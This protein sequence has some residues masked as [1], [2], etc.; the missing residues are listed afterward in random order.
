MSCLFNTKCSAPKVKYQ[1]RLYQTEADV[2]GNTVYRGQIVAIVVTL[3][4][5]VDVAAPIAAPDISSGTE[6]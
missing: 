5:S 4:V 3:L 2:I 1:R 6:L